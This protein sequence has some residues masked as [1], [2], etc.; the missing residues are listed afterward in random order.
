MPLPACILGAIMVTPQQRLPVVSGTTFPRTERVP[1]EDEVRGRQGL[2]PRMRKATRAVAAALFRTEQGPPP[3]DRLD[4]LVDDMDHFLALAGP[5]ARLI[6]RLC[7]FAISA[8]APLFVGRPPPY[9][10][11]SE[12]K[13]AVALERL[14]KSPLGITVF[15]CKMLLC[16]V[17]Y[18]H[19]DAARDIGFDGRCLGDEAS[20]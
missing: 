17:Y 14:E 2:T 15:G 10:A 8:L 4:W 18:E 6:Y 13:R 3:A 11:M 5:R 9:R 19:P 20:R 16:I 7:L 1:V 12:A